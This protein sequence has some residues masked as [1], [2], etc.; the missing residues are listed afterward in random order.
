MIEL[1]KL[2]SP[3]PLVVLLSEVVGLWLVLQQ[4]P[5]V[6]TVAPPSEVTSPPEEAEFAMIL[7]TAAIETVGAVLMASFLQL[8]KMDK[9]S[10]VRSTG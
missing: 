5:R 8:N 6:V 7:V 10:T 4:T 2:P 3:D 9:R 1:V